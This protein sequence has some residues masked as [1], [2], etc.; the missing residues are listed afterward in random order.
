MRHEG[1]VAGGSR[2]E[3]VYATDKD[4]STQVLFGTG[5]PGRGEKGGREDW[6]V[7]G[8]VLTRRGMRR[9]ESQHEGCVGPEV[10]DTRGKER[11]TLRTS[12]HDLRGPHSSRLKGTLQTVVDPRS[13]G[14][15]KRCRGGSNRTT[16]WVSTLVSRRVSTRRVVV[17]PSETKGSGPPHHL[18][19]RFS[20]VKPRIP[21]EE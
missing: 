7:E 6:G 2:R 14:H 21:E 10:G 17:R 18:D 13:R 1:D 5:Y 15:S 19:P 8:G 4:V 3:D 20:H 16:P 9:R 12:V 11:L